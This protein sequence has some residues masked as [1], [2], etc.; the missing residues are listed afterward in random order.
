[1]FYH[2]SI[3][4]KNYW[5]IIIIIIILPLTTP[6]KFFSI[7][8]ICKSRNKIRTIQITEIQ[9]KDKTRANFV[10][11][12]LH[13]PPD[14]R[15]HVGV[16]VHETLHSRGNVPASSGLL[17]ASPQQLLRLLWSVPPSR[18]LGWTWS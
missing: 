15:C 18:R 2:L 9:F 10:C 16:P 4:N 3:D 14:G 5:L 11:L 13:F 8:K 17:P 7:Y 1:M 6:S 12:C